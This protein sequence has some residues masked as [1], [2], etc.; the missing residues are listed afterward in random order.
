MNRRHY[1]DNPRTFL[2]SWSD[3]ALIE[4]LGGYCGLCEAIEGAKNS[5]LVAD[6]VDIC[7]QTV[8]VIEDWPQLHETGD[9]LHGWILK[10]LR[11]VVAEAT[12]EAKHA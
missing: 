2:H 3:Q 12:K 4:D 6:L 11:E 7:E 10:R 8:K 1:S 5:T 9:Y